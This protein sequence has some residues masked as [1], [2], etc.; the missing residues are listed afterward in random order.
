MVAALL[1]AKRMEDVKGLILFYPA[2]VIPDDARQNY[3]DSD[4]IPDNP[5]ALGN[6]VGKRY[7]M[8]VINMDIYAEIRRYEKDALIIH[9]YRDSTV[10][11]TYSERAVSEY[12][13]AELIVMDGAGHGFSGTQLEE[14]CDS[15]ANF[16][17]S[18]F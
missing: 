6:M 3:T 18:H 7:Y 13:S 9:G 12:P 11:I 16:I 4:H 14:A 15:A 10:P 1:A 8:D 5:T 2:F 17:N